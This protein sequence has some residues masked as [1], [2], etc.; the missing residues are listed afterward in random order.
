MNKRT[1]S[2]MALGMTAVLAAAFPIGVNAAVKNGGTFKD[3]IVFSS[4]ALSFNGQVIKDEAIA[5]KPVKIRVDNKELLT[6]LGLDE[7]TFMTEIK[8]G[9][10]LLQIAESKG[11]TKQQLIEF[12]TKQFTVKIDQ[13]VK[14][15]NLT[16]AQAA[17]M[18]VDFTSN[19]EQRLDGKGMMF[20]K[21]VRAIPGEAIA[22]KGVMIVADNKELLTL[23]GLDEAAFRTEIK[24]G[25]S[26]LQIAESKGITKAQ[27]N[28]FETKQFTANIDQAVKEGN[29]T[30]VQAAKMKEEFTA[31]VEQRLNGKGMFFT[32]SVR[33]IPGEAIAADNK[34]MLTLLGLDEATFMTE[35]K[36]GKS[37]LQIAESKGITK[38]QL[39]EFETKQF[40]VKIGQAVKDG[41][42]TEAQAAEMKV[43]FTANVEQFLNGKGMFFTKDV[44]FEL[45]NPAGS[46]D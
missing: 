35:I 2:L 33:A 6:F 16:E 27:L 19:A 5:G 37:L 14:E 44:K 7:A 21:S 22:G 31:N 32:K 25:K 26:L 39:I 42:L 28:E 20:T 24:S 23:L 10:S 4:K 17:E 18:K 3:G 1:K 13:A 36:S 9:K 11:I 15:G 12:E 45:S 38:Q 34:E 40:T 43:D 41:D 8:S 30:E 46:N 29:L